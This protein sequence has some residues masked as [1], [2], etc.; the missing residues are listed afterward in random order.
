MDP[1][2]SHRLV[3]VINN[4][5]RPGQYNT[6]SNIFFSCVLIY[7]L[8]SSLQTQEKIKNCLES[9]PGPMAY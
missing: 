3:H 7:R 9:N 2:R 6:N 4:C 1:S 5:E 8:L